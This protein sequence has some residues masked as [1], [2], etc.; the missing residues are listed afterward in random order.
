MSRGK[1]CL[2]GRINAT[3]YVIRDGVTGLLVDDPRSAKQVAEKILWLMAHP[4]QARDMGRAGYELV[5]S[6]YLFPNFK[7]RFWQ[8]LAA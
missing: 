2:G 3:P 7:Q 4:Q 8:A 6:Y 5:R 1:P